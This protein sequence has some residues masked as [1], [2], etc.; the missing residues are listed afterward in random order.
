MLLKSQLLLSLT[1]KSEMPGRHWMGHVVPL[2]SECPPLCASWCLDYVC[3]VRLDTVLGGQSY[4]STFFALSDVMTMFALLNLTLYGVDNPIII[5]SPLLPSQPQVLGPL[6]NS[7]NIQM[8]H[9][10]NCT[11]HGR[12]AEVR[13][14]S[15]YAAAV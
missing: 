12:S 5:V 15:T 1:T 13:L 10:A 11:Y 6:I 7:I 8:L 2:C 14:R 3:A 9:H 4:N